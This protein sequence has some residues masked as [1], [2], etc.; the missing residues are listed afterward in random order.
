MLRYLLR[1]LKWIYNMC[2]KDVPLTHLL[3]AAIVVTLPIIFILGWITSWP[4]WIRIIIG[5][6]APFVIGGIDYYN[7]GCF[8]G[9]PRSGHTSQSNT[10]VNDTSNYQAP[11]PLNPEFIYLRDKYGS[12]IGSR[13]QENNL[14]M[15]RD[16]YGYVLGWYNTQ[17]GL[18]HDQYGSVYGHGDLLSA[19]L[20]S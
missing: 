1:G 15:M 5:I 2:L 16:K 6:I 20:N 3:G 10:T 18:T 13:R 8:T 14:I 11:P 4:L 9:I 12:I 19:L 17:T 7:D